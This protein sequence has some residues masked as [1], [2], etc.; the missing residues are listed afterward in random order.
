[1]LAH[2]VERRLEKIGR[3]HSG[4]FD[5]VLKGQKNP[6][7]GPHFGTHGNKSLP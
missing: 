7:P 2:R 5:R 4:N 6:F 3:A 1:M